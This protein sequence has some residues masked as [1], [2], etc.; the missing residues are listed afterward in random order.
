[1]S[2]NGDLMRKA[3]KRHWLPEMTRLGFVGAGSH[4][5]R[6]EPEA[7]DLLTLQYW[8]F[9]GEFILE[10]ARRCRGPFETT[11][12]KPIPE[13][14]MEV[15]YLN[16]LERARLEQ[17]G[18]LTGPHLRGF[19]FSTFGEDAGEYEKLAL[20]VPALMPC[21]DHWLRH[22]TASEHIHAFRRAP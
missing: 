17:R 8:K 7:Q 2:R 21:V 22:G 16:P 3:L 20:H 12:G 13:S 4:Y 11:W 18:P 14:E 19:D 5:R 15:I 1:M 6:L 10:F 9:G